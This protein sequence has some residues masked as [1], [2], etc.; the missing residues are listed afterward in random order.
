MPQRHSKSFISVTEYL[1]GEQV[2]NTRHEY[3]N[4]TV[5]A[6][7]GG[8]DR[9]GLITANLGGLLNLRLPE[10][11]QVFIADMKVHIETQNQD[12]F[13]Y[14]DVLVSC[15]EN[16]RE[17]YFRRRPCLLIEVLS[18]STERLDRFEKFLFYQHLESLQEYLLVAQSMVEIQ[19]FRRSNQWGAEIYT[20]NN[21]PLES[22]GLTVNV[23]DIYRRVSF[24]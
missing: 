2:G 3:V 20:E 11:C 8:S 5:Y 13:Y 16:D 24:N 15:D 6:M 9:H 22:V 7:V 1:E 23:N 21:I 17:T 12:I 4:G 18:P 10:R 19:V 14:P